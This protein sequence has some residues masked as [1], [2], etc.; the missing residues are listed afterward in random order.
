MCFHKWKPSG[1]IL[2][3]GNLAGGIN[4]TKEQQKLNNKVNENIV[5]SIMCCAVYISSNHNFSYF[6]N[7]STVNM[8]CITYV[9]LLRM[10][11]EQYN[12]NYSCCWWFWLRRY[13][14]TIATY[15]FVWFISFLCMLLIKWANFTTLSSKNYV[16]E[17][18]NQFRLYL[19]ALIAA[20]HSDLSFSLLATKYSVYWGN[21]LPSNRSS[22]SL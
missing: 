12:H 4:F 2:P 16:Y 15:F 13:M 1:Y 14:H 22:V 6:S 3:I 17:K 19:P 8:A 11:S 9:E 20:I 7:K 18:K 10:R 5:I 21:D